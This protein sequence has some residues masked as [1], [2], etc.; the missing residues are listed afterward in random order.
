MTVL[1][2]SFIVGSAALAA[3][4][5]FANGDSAAL[6]AL[7]FETGAIELPDSHGTFFVPPDAKAAEGPDALQ[8]DEIINASSGSNKE[9]VV[10][11][12]RGLVYLSYVD[13]G[14]VTVNDWPNFDATTMLSGIRA[15]TDATNESRVIDGGEPVSVDGWVQAPTFDPARRTVSYVVAS[16][17]RTRRFVNAVALELGRFGYERIVIVG[18]DCDATTIA[19]MLADVT[20]RYTFDAG[21]RWSDYAP[22]DKIAAVGLAALLGTAGTS[23]I[24]KAPEVGSIEFVEYLIAILI[25]CAA[26]YAQILRLYG[27]FWIGSRKAPIASSPDTS[28]DPSFFDRH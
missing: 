2:L 15:A 24:A 25:V 26:V 5:R 18:H 13:S 1:L 14:F 4:E 3:D 17:D 21:F 19:A 9:G 16:H 23:K 6:A 27:G 12:K 7:H 8:A 20:K 22:D 11:L 28:V 10:F